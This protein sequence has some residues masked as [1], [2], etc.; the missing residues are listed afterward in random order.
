MIKILKQHFKLKLYLKTN[1]AITVIMDVQNKKNKQ[2]KLI[3]NKLLQVILINLW[4]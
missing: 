2:K 4:L 3:R 1:K